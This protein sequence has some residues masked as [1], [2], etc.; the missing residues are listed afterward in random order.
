[1]HLIELLEDGIKFGII[2]EM[3]FVGDL[4]LQPLT[5][6]WAISGNRTACAAAAGGFW[7][8]KDVL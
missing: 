8:E 1:L 2:R 7:F 6:L 3:E 5:T 4:G